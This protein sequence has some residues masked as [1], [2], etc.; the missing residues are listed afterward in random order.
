MNKEKKCVDEAP[1]IT[2]PD[3]ESRKRS[4]FYKLRE[5]KNRLDLIKNRNPYA[6]SGMIRK[7]SIENGGLGY[8][9]DILERLLEKGELDAHTFSLELSERD[10]FFD[11]NKYDLA[12]GIIDD[13]CRTGGKNLCRGTGL[14][15][16]F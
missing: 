1:I 5:Y 7:I 6:H 2:L 4:L 9:I 14:P 12:A 16:G 10:G 15:S 3:E 8:K 13:Y 11:V